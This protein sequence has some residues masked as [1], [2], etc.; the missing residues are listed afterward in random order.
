MLNKT[1]IGEFSLEG[2]IDILIFRVLF[3]RGPQVADNESQLRLLVL[4]VRATKSPEA[5]TRELKAPCR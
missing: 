3:F 5:G 4:A 2:S 1:S